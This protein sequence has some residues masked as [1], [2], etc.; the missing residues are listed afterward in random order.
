MADSPM[1]ESGE[2]GEIDIFIVTVARE[3]Y[4]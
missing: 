3:F 1:D 2:T 4:D